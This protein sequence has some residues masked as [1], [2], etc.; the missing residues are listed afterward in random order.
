MFCDDPSPTYPEYLP[1]VAEP[2]DEHG[3]AVRGVER[4]RHRPPR[5]CTVGPTPA[6]PPGVARHRP[7]HGAPRSC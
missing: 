2:A 1:R 6:R 4:E 7:A 5:V 3:R